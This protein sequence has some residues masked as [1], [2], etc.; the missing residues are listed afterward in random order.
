MS[1]LII[2]T[3]ITALLIVAISEIAKKSSLFAGLLAS[4]PITSFL[5]FIWLYW[6]TNDPQKVINLSNSIILMIIPSLIFFIILPISLKLNIPFTYS[7]ILSVTITAFSYWVYV[8]VLN[9]FKIYL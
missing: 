7:M 6:E 1:Y 8:M 3:I 5:A 9:S 2:K 4:I